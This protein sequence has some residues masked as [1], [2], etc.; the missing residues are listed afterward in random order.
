MVGLRELMV[1]V[2]QIWTIRDL[3][4]AMFVVAHNGAMGAAAFT[5]LLA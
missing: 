4:I 2:V 1:G 5:N 3:V